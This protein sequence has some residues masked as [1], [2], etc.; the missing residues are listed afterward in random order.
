MVKFLLLATAMVAVVAPASSAVVLSYEA[1][2]VTNTTQTGTFAVETFDELPVGT[3]ISPTGGFTST[4]FS[5]AIDGV[6]FSYTGVSI[7]NDQYGNGTNYAAVYNGVYGGTN[8]NSAGYTLN[9]ARTTGTDP[10]NYFG[11]FVSAADDS[12]TFTFYNGT[13]KIGV[14]NLADL[15]AQIGVADQG[16]FFANFNFTNGDTYTKVVF[17]QPVAC[18]GF[19]SDNHTVGTFVSPP[20]PGTGIALP[21]PE[22]ATWAMMVFGFGM[23]GSAVRRRRQTTARA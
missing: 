23:A 6:V 4:N 9:V 15:R 21:V 11:L 3:P 1:A 2:G 7:K 12:N 18:C 16:A 5:Q 8:N 13:T 22:A 10:L 19:E 14:F 20:V 17:S